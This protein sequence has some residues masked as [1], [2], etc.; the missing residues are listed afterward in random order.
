MLSNTFANDL[1]KLIFQGLPIAGIADNAA[2]APL[3]LLYISMHTA[4]PTGAGSQES[5]EVSYTG[6]NRIPLE[7]N[8]TKWAITGNVVRPAGRIEF[9]EM[10]AGVEQLATWISIGTSPS[11]AGK[12]L[13]RAKLNPNIQVRTGVIPA[14]KQQSAL[15][16]VT[17][18]AG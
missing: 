11:G 18:E 17:T 12:I 9:G 16:F 5:A 7:R 13:M 15:T 8:S 3:T 10:T 1:A 6:Y 14:V 2:S 4:D